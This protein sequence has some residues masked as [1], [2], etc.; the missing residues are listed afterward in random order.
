MIL[1]RRDI[2][3]ELFVECENVERED[4]RL[5]NHAISVLGYNVGCKRHGDAYIFSKW[6]VRHG[7]VEV[8]QVKDGW[9]R[10]IRNGQKMAT[11]HKTYETLLEALEDNQ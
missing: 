11:E 1:I 8:W 2:M 6:S 10:C 3:S 5:V 7:T 4:I 9:K